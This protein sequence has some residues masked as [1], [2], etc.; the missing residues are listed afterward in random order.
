MQYEDVCSQ[1]TDG[2][3][4]R[5]QAQAAV[6]RLMAHYVELV[7]KQDPAAAELEAAWPFLGKTKPQGNNP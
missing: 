4:D 1:P 6:R 5:E 3:V 7:E 2:A